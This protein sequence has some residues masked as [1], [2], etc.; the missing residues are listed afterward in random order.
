MPLIGVIGGSGLY[1]IPGLGKADDRRVSTPFGEP[2]GPYRIGE[3]SGVRVAFLPRHGIHHT[4]PPHR[5]NYRANIRGFKDLGVRRLISINATGGIDPGLRPGDIVLPDQV[6]DMTQGARASTFYDSG[7]VVHVDF[8]DPYCPELRSCLIRAAKDAGIGLRRTTGT[9]VC[10]N[11]PRLESRAETR[12]FGSMGAHLVG[13]TGM[14]EAALARELQMCMAPLAV[15]TN[16]APGISEKKLTTEE[17]VREMQ[18]SNG[19]INRLLISALPLIPPERDC[20]CKSAL[21][22]AGMKGPEDTSVSPDM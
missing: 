4:V 10:V 17:V 22:G 3:V 8:T 14:P 21:Q 19:L 18:K 12:M 1:D 6:L 13:M 7:E 11:G 15:V 2:S 20:P 9:Y 5:I 16:Y